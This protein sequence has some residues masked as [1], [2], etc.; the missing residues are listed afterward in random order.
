MAEPHV[1]HLEDV[2]AV[3]PHHGSI[4]QHLPPVRVLAQVAGGGTTQVLR[5]DF[6]CA[7]FL[8]DFLHQLF[9]FKY[10]VPLLA[11]L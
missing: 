6:L 7:N 5:P 4:A 2:D 8:H 3:K 1:V 10:L 11:N 9:V